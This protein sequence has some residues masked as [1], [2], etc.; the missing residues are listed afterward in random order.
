MSCMSVDLCKLCKLRHLIFFWYKKKILFL[1][2]K[3]FFLY[4]KKMFFL[5]KK[6]VFLL[7]KKN[8][9]FLYDL[10]LYER[11]FT[12]VPNLSEP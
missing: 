7:Y 1:Y 11:Y 5:T 6:T 3:I 8:M 2:K 10:F 9:I 4:K 12:E